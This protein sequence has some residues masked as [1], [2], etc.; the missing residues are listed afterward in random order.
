MQT[1]KIT[2]WPLAFLL[3]GIV[4]V[5]AKEPKL[6]QLNVVFRHADRAPETFPKR[7]PNDPHMYE[8]FHPIGP[9]G[10][11]NEGKRRVYHFGE[12]LRNRYRDF[13]GSSRDDHRESLFAISSDVARTKIS[14]QL[15]LAGLYPPSADSK[16]HE[17]LEWQP[18][19]TYYNE[20]SKDTLFNSDRCQM[21]IDELTRVSSLPDVQKKLGKFD[22]Y[23]EELRKTV[24]K[25][26]KLNLNDILLLHNN[27]DIEKR[28]NLTMLPWMNDVLA[29]ERLIE[30]RRLY[31]E[32]NSYTDLLK[33]L[34]SGFMLRKI[35]EDMFEGST[36]ANFTRKITLYSGHDKNIIAL[37]QS[38]KIY[39]G[40]FPDFT[41]ALIFELWFHD[42]GYYVKIF[43][44]LG[45]PE[46]MKEFTIP[47]CANP[48]SLAE[49]LKLTKAAEVRDNELNCK[50][51]STTYFSETD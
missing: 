33:R 34:L 35:N 44:Y 48:C 9:G 45:I 4:F 47:G 50:I 39:D 16:W 43:Y 10:L 46:E 5:G 27:L 51:Y 7:F 12:V 40:H 22:T 32:I 13:L 24:G 2:L 21:F 30:M 11:T 17:Q 42:E 23:L 20:F 36:N 6:R 31:Y 15:A 37:L 41:S 3:L 38:L 14:L 18:I 49:Y 8:S 26:S 29:D 1:S 25:K 19:P 28:M